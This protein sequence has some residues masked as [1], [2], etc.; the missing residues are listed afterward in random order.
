MSTAFFARNMGSMWARRRKSAFHITDAQSKSQER[1][2]QRENA[3][4]V[5]EQLSGREPGGI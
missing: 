2:Y 3:V 4:N 1:Y 5:R